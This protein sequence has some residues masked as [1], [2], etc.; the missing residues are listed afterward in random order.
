L[1]AKYARQQS[2]IQQAAADLRAKSAQANF[3][4]LDAARY[5][6]LALSEA[7]SRQNAERTSAEEEAARSAVESAQL[8]LLPQS[9]N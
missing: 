2:V 7:C 9:S 4:K 3:A 5:R 6:S 1:R 8:R